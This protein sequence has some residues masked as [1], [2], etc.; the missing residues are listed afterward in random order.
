MT[1][2]NV[3]VS[4][5]ETLSDESD[6]LRF[7]ERMAVLLPQVYLHAS[8]LPYVAEAPDFQ[9]NT[10]HIARRELALSPDD[11]L[12]RVYNPFVADIE[13]PSL[14]ELLVSI[15]DE[16]EESLNA[17]LSDEPDAIATA[18]NDLRIGFAGEDRWGHDLLTALSTIH[19]AK[20]RL[21]EERRIDRLRR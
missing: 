8:Q 11:P 19:R 13:G 17:L 7:V 10:L 12:A 2:C 1:L 16:I 15:R 5:D 3:L 18:I 14:A 20:A 6:L 9:C 21:A 4:T